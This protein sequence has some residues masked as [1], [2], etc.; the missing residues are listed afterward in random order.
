MQQTERNESPNANRRLTL[1]AA[2]VPSVPEIRTLLSR[3]IFKPPH[4]PPNTIQWSI[5]RQRHQAQAAKSHYK[6]RHNTQ[7]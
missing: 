7:L 5:R 6:R 3:L 4:R 1:L 2:L